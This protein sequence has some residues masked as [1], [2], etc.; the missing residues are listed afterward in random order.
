MIPNAELRRIIESSFLPLN[1]HCDIRP[2]G[3]MT[4]EVW[5]SVTGQ[6]DLLAVGVPTTELVTI[7]AVNNLVAELR[8]ELRANQEWFERTHNKDGKPTS[9]SAFGSDGNAK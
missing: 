8:G 7:R 1:C 3:T 6:V 9:F 5:D 4:I 2:G